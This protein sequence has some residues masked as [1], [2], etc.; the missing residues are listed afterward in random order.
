VCVCVCARNLDQPSS[1]NPSYNG[2]C[3]CHLD[4]NKKIKKKYINIYNNN[5]KNA[6]AVL[7][8]TGLARCNVWLVE[9]IESSRAEGPNLRFRWRRCY[10]HM[11]VATHLNNLYRLTPRRPARI[12][13]FIYT[14]LHA[15][16]R[17]V[18]SLVFV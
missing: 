14:H 16:T 18:S 15:H 10:R 12:Y 11:Q 17:G 3:V 13:I 7:D 1:D 8:I 6:H 2:V 9:W 5:N 4:R